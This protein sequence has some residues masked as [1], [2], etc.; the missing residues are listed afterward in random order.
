M[1]G[2]LATRDPARDHRASTMA[3]ENAGRMTNTRDPARG[4]RASTETKEIDTGRS[5][6]ARDPATG[7][8]AST[9]AIEGVV[10]VG[11]AWS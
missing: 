1:G 6:E 7:W 11:L 5:L 4:W 2:L 9:M 10:D 8:R 3:T